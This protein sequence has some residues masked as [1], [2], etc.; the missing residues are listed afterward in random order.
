MQL[1][2]KSNKN[3]SLS[4][5]VFYPDTGLRSSGPLLEF[6]TTGFQNAWDNYCKTSCNNVAM[7]LLISFYSTPLCHKLKSA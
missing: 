6:S 4:T 1:K 5:S 3:W 2:R 7:C